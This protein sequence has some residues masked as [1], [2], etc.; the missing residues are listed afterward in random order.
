MVRYS[1]RDTILMTKI[2]INKIRVVHLRS[3]Q[4]VV[5]STHVIP[6]R[7]RITFLHFFYSLIF[8]FSMFF[9]FLIQSVRAKIRFIFF[10][11]IC[12]IK[13]FHH[14]F[15]MICAWI[16]QI[17]CRLLSVLLDVMG[18]TLERDFRSSS[19][20]FFHAFKISGVFSM[21]LRV[22]DVPLLF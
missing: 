20:C 22:V 9:P 21:L 7:W 13:F 11:P 17:Q 8:R 1:H 18:S 16:A 5:C 10:I 4:C 2:G 6:F 12:F 15:E 14:L 3:S 19:L